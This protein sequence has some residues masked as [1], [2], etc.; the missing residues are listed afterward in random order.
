MRLN[1]RQG[2]TRFV[3]LLLLV[4]TFFALFLPTYGWD[5][6]SYH[7]PFSQLLWHI[8]GYTV[9]K[10]GALR[11]Y[12][13]LGFPK[14]AEAAQGF[15]WYITHRQQSVT[16][17]HLIV[18]ACYLG[19]IR[20]FFR[21][22]LFLLILALFTC[23]MVMIAYSDSYID[24]FSSLALAIAFFASIHLIWRL[25]NVTSPVKSNDYAFAAIALVVASN[26]K[27]PAYLSSIILL[28]MILFQLLAS[29]R[30]DSKLKIKATACIALVSVCCSI[31]PITNA[32]RFHDPFYPFTM[33][34]GHKVIV[35]GP[36]APYKTDPG[37]SVA[38]LNK[39]NHGHPLAF[40]SFPP[41]AFFLSAS[42]LDW[43]IRGLPTIYSIDESM[44][45]APKH[46]QP[47]RTGGW[48][49][50]YFLLLS[51]VLCLRLYKFKAISGTFLGKCLINFFAF[52]FLTTFLPQ[53]FELRYYLYI[54]LIMIPLALKLCLVNRSTLSCVKVVLVV[55]FF[56]Y[57]FHE[58]KFVRFPTDTSASSPGLKQMQ[59]RY[60][61]EI[62]N[63][64]SE[65]ISS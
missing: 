6:P 39:T 55:M 7:F 59:D 36:E 4:N 26:S 48:G 25:E 10:L 40:L 51:A 37:Y 8:G 52:T 29:R 33:E 3:F 38:F 43:S 9:D 20:S 11:Y 5:S 1:L 12:R 34:I 65:G 15:F 13:W 44:G 24:L 42:E 49:G 60:E 45:D 14:F 53:S 58:H 57:F 27:Y 23:P 32:I 2:L 47:S 35:E 54:P 21:L 17:P 63:I 28:M 64:S 22:P 18:F 19:I 61:N 41:I 31:V 50:V 30:I 56:Y 16:W 46:G 62:R